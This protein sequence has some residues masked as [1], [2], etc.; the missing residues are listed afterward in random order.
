MFPK[1][2]LHGFLLDCVMTFF[3]SLWD[4]LK[5]WLQPKG[6][7]SRLEY[8]STQG[9][10][11]WLMVGLLTAFDALNWDDS[12]VG[13]LV[14]LTVGIS[15]FVLTLAKRCTDMGESFS[16]LAKGLIPIL[17]L[18]YW[19]ELLWR[20]GDQDPDADETLPAERFSRPW[21]VFHASLVS[22]TLG[23]PVGWL[24]TR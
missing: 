22:I 13:L 3:E 24:L 19:L 21:L 10:N 20:P 18:Y 23:F 1:L 11:F 17:C 9:I 14:I 5:H 12:L 7:L 2:H 8:V 15:L 4:W 16:Y 6:R